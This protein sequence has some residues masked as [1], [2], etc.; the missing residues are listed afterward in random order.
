MRGGVEADEV[1]AVPVLP[2]DGS[3][4]GGVV[5][6]GFPGEVFALS[7]SGGGGINREVLVE[8]GVLASG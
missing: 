2:V 1:G 3:G 4:S 7:V 5:F 6:D 8:E